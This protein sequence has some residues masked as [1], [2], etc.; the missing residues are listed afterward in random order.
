VSG[1]DRHNPPHFD[2]ATGRSDPVPLNANRL[3]EEIMK[4]WKRPQV[5]E[6]EVGLEVTS[7]LPAEID[8]I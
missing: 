3:A 2:Q 1:S 8:I 6:Q 5:R 4:S 7:Y